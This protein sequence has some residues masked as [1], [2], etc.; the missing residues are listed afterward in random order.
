[1]PLGRAERGAQALGEQRPVRQVGQRVVE[2]VVLQLRLQYD[3]FG[4]VAAVQDQPV[5]VPVDRRLDVQPLVVA[6]PD[7]ALHPGRGLGRAV[8]ADRPV[9]HQPTDL[10]QHPV[11]VLGVHQVEQ[12]PADQLLRVPAVDADRGGADVGEQAAAMRRS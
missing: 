9:R 8:P 10:A 3:P 1:M 11:D 7:P 12:V 2:R 5:P 4:D 6:G